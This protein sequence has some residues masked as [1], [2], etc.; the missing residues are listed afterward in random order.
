[1]A[2]ASLSRV[3][4]SVN[5]GPWEFRAGLA[6]VGISGFAI[7]ADQ[8]VPGSPVCPIHAMTGLWCPGCG[9]TRAF[10]EMIRFNINGA[11]Q[12]N[13]FS[14]VFGIFLIWSV[15]A[16][17]LPSYLKRPSVLPGKL[18]LAIYFALL[19][20]GVARNIPDFQWLGPT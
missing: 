3:V 14:P 1:M 13:I 2:K 16:W 7:I 17:I 18:W 15:L 4:S 20:F 9:V 19:T 12:Y 6:L 5:N 11:L 10:F 8:G